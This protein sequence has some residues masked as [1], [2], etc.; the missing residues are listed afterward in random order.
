MK[1]ATPDR[2]IK[3]SYTAPADLETDKKAIQA[4]KFENSRATHGTPALFT[5]PSNFGALPLRAM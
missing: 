1:V 3:A 4:H 2:V 5:R